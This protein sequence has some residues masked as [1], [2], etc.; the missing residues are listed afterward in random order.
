[1]TDK[2]LQEIKERC[3][4]ASAGPWKKFSEHENKVFSIAVDAPYSE[5]IVFGDFVV[6]RDGDFWSYG[7]YR[8]ENAD[9]IAHAR[10]DI[11]ALLKEI[12]ILN[13]MVRILAGNDT[14][15]CPMLQHYYNCKNGYKHPAECE[16]WY[17]LF[18]CWKYAA[19]KEA[20]EYIKSKE[21][22]KND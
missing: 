13:E 5:P 16:S 6:E 9:F 2:Q 3:N 1:M 7:V 14:N 22:K 10:E 17:N 11:P 8:E 12:D 21:N 4:K 20:E 18:D 19:R 15:S